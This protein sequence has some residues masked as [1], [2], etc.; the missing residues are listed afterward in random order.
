[1]GAY[2]YSF[3]LSQNVRRALLRGNRIAADPVRWCI[4]LMLGV[5]SS[6]FSSSVLTFEWVDFGGQN[7]R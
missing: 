2:N 6:V 1:M 7:S 5:Y 4:V 3:K